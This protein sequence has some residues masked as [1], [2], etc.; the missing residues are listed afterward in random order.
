MLRPTLKKLKVGAENSKPAPK[1]EEK[2][3]KED[4]K[5]L[6]PDTY[7]P[8]IEGVE[9]TVTDKMKLCFSVSRKGDYGLPH[10][11]IREFV[12]TEV[13]TGLTKKGINFNIEYL[14]EF[15]GIL[16][17]ISAECEKKGL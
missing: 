14:D 2:P 13:Y 4:K 5:K 11:D 9:L 3:K 8:I 12:M 7:K 10:V 6:P 1:V 16:Q 17:K 15:I